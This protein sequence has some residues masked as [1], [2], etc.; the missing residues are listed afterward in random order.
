MIKKITDINTLE[1]IQ[2]NLQEKEQTLALIPTMGALHDGH[3]ALVEEGL[4]R[5]DKVIVSIFVNPTQFA[6]NEDFEA[7]PR[8][9]D[10]DLEKLENLG[11]SEV[12]LPETEDIYPNGPKT[13]IKAGAIAKPLEGEFRPHFFD[14][15]VT[16]LHRMFI[17][18]KPDMAIFGEK[19]FQQLQVIKQMVQEQNI[20]VD[21]IGVPTMRDENGLALSSRNVYLN[22]DEYKIAIQLNKILTE[23]AEGKINE[24]QAHKKL[25]GAGFN[26]IDYCT[27][28]NSKNFLPENPTRVL[29]AVWIGKTRLIDNIPLISMD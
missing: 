7:Y 4:K 28:R 23:M 11:I 17:L 13:N 20:P 25:Q 12:W 3:L 19:D 6:P 29:A 16:V 1:N 26:K 22:D 10:D 9:I 15:V 21:I 5:V 14:G 2:Q 18:S 8:T 24:S 27:L